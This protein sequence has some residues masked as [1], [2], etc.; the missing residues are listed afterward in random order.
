MT[1]SWSTIRLNGVLELQDFVHARPS[2][3]LACRSP[4][5][6]AGH[7]FGYFRTLAVEI[8]PSNSRFSVSVLP[9]NRFRRL[10]GLPPNFAFLP[11]PLRVGH[12]LSS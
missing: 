6:T 12:A 9:D 10:P 1:V 5:A 3:D 8:A 7:Y 4:L 11:F 2:R